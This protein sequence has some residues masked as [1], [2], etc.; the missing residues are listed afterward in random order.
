MICAAHADQDTIE[1]A[2][3]VE[4]A[5]CGGLRSRH[6]W[7]RNDLGVLVCVLVDKAGRVIF[8]E[9]A[10]YLRLGLGGFRAAFA[11]LYLGKMGCNLWYIFVVNL[12]DKLCTARF[13]C[14]EVNGCIMTEHSSQV[15]HVLSQPSHRNGFGGIGLDVQRVG[16]AHFCSLAFRSH[17]VHSHSRDP[18]QQFDCACPRGSKP[19]PT[20]EQ[21]ALGS[22]S[23]SWEDY[24]NWFE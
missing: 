19:V 24:T 17:R 3:L 5:E 11:P 14:V 9:Q 2:F 16:L 21:H 8:C 1:R 10:V 6:A 12:R 20:F 15:L 23:F 18:L 13:Q 22:L 4:R 7:E